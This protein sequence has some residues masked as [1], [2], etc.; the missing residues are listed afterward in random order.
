MEDNDFC[1]S[2]SMGL[3]FHECEFNHCQRDVLLN[4]KQKKL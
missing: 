1:F 2:D 4:H 3:Q